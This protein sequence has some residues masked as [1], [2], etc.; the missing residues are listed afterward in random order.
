MCA[1][2][3]RIAYAVEFVYPTWVLEM[4]NFIRDEH[5]TLFLE[6]SQVNMH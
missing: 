6:I 2:D 1:R 4:P 5:R 3:P